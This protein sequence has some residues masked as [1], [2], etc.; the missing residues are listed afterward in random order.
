M[1]DPNERYPDNAPGGYYVDTNCI[2]CD[3][4]R[5]SARGNFRRNEEGGYSFVYKQPETEAERAVCELVRDECPVA[6]IGN[7]G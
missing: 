3:I 1:A 2:D 4:C 5:D 6:A 7:N